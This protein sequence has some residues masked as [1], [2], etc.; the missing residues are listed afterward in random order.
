M[1]D[2]EHRSK[3]E[4]M[5]SVQMPLIELQMAARKAAVEQQQKEQGKKKEMR[6]KCL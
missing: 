1:R 2:N 3:F 5:Q 6:Q 4:K